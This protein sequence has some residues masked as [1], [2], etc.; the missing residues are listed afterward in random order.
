MKRHALEV[1]AGER[2]KFGANW[3]NFLAGLTE[4]GVAASTEHLRST[5]N[6]EN[7]EGKAFLDVGSGSGLTSLSAVRLGAKVTSF[8][9][10]PQSVECTKE[11][12]R[13]FANQDG[14]WTITEGSALDRDFLST[15]GQFDVVCSWG[16]LHHTGSMWAAME[17]MVPLV[18]DGG[19]LYIAIY[20]DQ[21]PW[22]R[23]WAAIKKTYNRLPGPLAA[24]FAVVVMGPRELRIALGALRRFQLG[25]YL[26]SWFEVADQR[27]RGMSRYHDI[28]DWVG[29]Y[30]FEVAKPEEVFDFY[31][32]RG[33]VLDKLLTC[34]GGLGCN[35][36]VFHRQP[37]T[38]PAPTDK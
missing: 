35:H 14:N 18:K 21:G 2:F 16:V 25:T 8:D 6:V 37:R 3:T 27:T 19:T 1:S 34:G 23:R 12:H 15:L 11:L 4:T 17:N 31:R 5:L 28:V 7:L 24:L 33:F 13:R 10:D 26:K 30:P 9:Y 22:S 32:D 20:N 36:Y 29:G 38:Q